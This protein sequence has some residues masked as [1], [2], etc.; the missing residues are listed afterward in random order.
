MPKSAAPAVPAMTNALRTMLPSR[1]IW[2]TKP[3]FI[4][5]SALQLCV[6]PHID[7]E[8]LRRRH[9]AGIGQHVR[10][11]DRD[12]RMRVEEGAEGR[13]FAIEQVVY[14]PVDLPLLGRLVRAAQ[15]RDPVI[16]E[17]RVLVGVVANKPLTTDPDDVGAELQLRREPVIDATLDRVPRYAGNLL[18]W[19][20]E[21]VPIC[22][23]ERIVW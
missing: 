13:E 1:P 18:A 8:R 21:D 22:V 7:R 5:L 11:R 9:R 17:L 3:V 6:H 15:I 2:I 16:G 20:D 10:Y 4:C 14:D 19:R 12:R 23:R